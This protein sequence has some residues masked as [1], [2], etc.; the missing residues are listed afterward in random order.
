MGMP[1]RDNSDLPSPARPHLPEHA[2]DIDREAFNPAFAAHGA[3]R[4][5]S[6]PRIASPGR[7]SSVP[8][9]EP[10]AIPRAGIG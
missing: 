4:V 9:E 2:R 7:Q 10:E 1:Y 5:G 8:M 6:K 3:P